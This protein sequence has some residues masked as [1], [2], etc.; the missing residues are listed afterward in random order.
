MQLRSFLT[1]FALM[2]CVSLFAQNQ[3]ER[4]TNRA[5]NRAENKA[6]N[7]VDRS[8]DKAVDDTFN[9]IGNLFK[10]KKK[11]TKEQPAGAP[12][13]VDQGGQAPN[14]GEEYTS[15]EE[16][17]E[18][19]NNALN[20]GSNEPYE[21][22]TNPYTFSLDME[23]NETKKNGKVETNT[24][25]MA[26]TSSFFAILI[27][28]P[29]GNGAS[30][31]IF[32]TEDGKTTMITTDK[33]GKKSGFRMKMPGTGRAMAEAAEDVAGR[34]TF[35]QT[36]E[37]KTIEGYDCEKIIVKDNKEGTTTESWITQDLEISTTDV[38]G[39]IMSAFGNKTK[40]GKSNVMKHPLQGFPIRSTTVEDGKTYVTNF[41]NIKIGEDKYDS[42]LLDTSGVEIQSLGF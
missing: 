17:M 11:K 42:S 1:I 25:S 12:A 40:L 13:P 19:I 35:T 38:F 4:A 15:E 28:D 37:R 36:G 32:N 20:G 21:G 10:K 6:Q 31:M 14:N 29:K 16:A 34:F 39:G 26:V 41:R 23:I 24:I 3:A 18:A 30:Q 22:Y 5:K 33:K 2:C 7:K 9:A 8:V 27:K